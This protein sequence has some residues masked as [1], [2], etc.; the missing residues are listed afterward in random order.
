MDDDLASLE[1]ASLFGAGYAEGDQSFATTT[2]SFMEYSADADEVSRGEVARSPPS[3]FGDTINMQP[4]RSHYLLEQYLLEHESDSESIISDQASFLAEN[5]AY[6]EQHPITPVSLT[7][8]TAGAESRAD[9]DDD[10][11]QILD[12]DDDFRQI[13]DCTD[14]E[15]YYEDDEESTIYPDGPLF[16]DDL[17]MS[18]G[19]CQDQDP[20]KKSELD[21]SAYNQERGR[22]LAQRLISKARVND[23]VEPKTASTPK[24]PS[25]IASEGPYPDEPEQKKPFIRN[26]F[27]RRKRL[28]MDYDIVDATI[29]DVV[30]PL[31][32]PN[33]ND[34]NSCLA[35]SGHSLA[36]SEH[37][38][39]R[40]TPSSYR[41]NL[42]S[43]SLSSGTLSELANEG[44][45]DDFN[46]ET[47]EE[48][49][50]FN[51]LKGSAV[52][53]IPP[54]GL[55][56]R[57]TAEEVISQ[58][59]PKGFNDETNDENPLFDV[60][61]EPAVSS[62][63]PRGL[64]RR[65]TAEEA[66]SQILPKGLLRRATVEEVISQIKVGSNGWTAVRQ[67]RELLVEASQ[68]SAYCSAGPAEDVAPF[69]AI[70]GIEVRNYQACVQ[71]SVANYRRNALKVSDEAY[72]EMLKDSKQSFNSPGIVA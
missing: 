11:R 5:D 56:R 65:A 68:S 54:K 61:K 9:Y 44:D 64:L 67:L 22:F 16:E 47:D 30:P 34:S 37:S 19:F 53:S 20:R 6:F 28:D 3:L 15:V 26:P 69:F 38:P 14:S 17:S 42:R 58:I 1:S 33:L 46:D 50:F 71:R 27:A 29:K 39:E 8:T 2:R 23:D 35:D 32:T 24:T 18:D 60:L 10:V 7:G 41:N 31:Q 25:T 59:L 49:P 13:L 45:T 12:C 21:W 72:E 52:S 36:D 40:S 51:V 62:I 4:A 55:L 70:Q 57:A 63:L 43:D 66:I 48:D